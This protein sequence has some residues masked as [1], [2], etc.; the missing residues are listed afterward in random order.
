[1]VKIN[2][3]ALYVHWKFRWVCLIYV[4][5]IANR[6]TLDA[7]IL[8]ANGGSMLYSNQLKKGER[9]RVPNCSNVFIFDGRYG[10]NI[11]CFT[12]EHDK[13]RFYGREFIEFENGKAYLNLEHLT[14]ASA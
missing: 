4:R 2:R 6:V 1:M 13:Y 5:W 3:N 12:R 14:T 7:G 10:N 11:K 9:Y 8:T